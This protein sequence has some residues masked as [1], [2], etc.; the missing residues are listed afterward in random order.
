MKVQKTNAVRGNGSSVGG[1]IE[2]KESTKNLSPQDPR[3]RAID[4]ACE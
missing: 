4:E 2:V 1:S 3:R